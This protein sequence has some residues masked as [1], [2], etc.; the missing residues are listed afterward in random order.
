MKN[1]YLIHVT[2]NWCGMDDTYRAISDDENKL[3]DIAEELAYDNFLMYDL[4]NSIA[5]EEG[6]DPEEMSENDWNELY[7]KVDESSYY[8]FS[9]E[10]FDGDDEEWEGYTGEIYEF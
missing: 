10:K 9:I 1:K 6:Y 4:W 2:T 8:G 5:E 3:Y 7:D